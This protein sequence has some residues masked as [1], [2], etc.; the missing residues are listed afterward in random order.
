MLDLNEELERW[1]EDPKLEALLELLID[2]L[3]ETSPRNSAVE[4][5]R[6]HFKLTKNI[7]K[8]LEALMELA[9]KVA[10]SVEALEDQTEHL[11]S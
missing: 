6:N 5:L 7:S 2:Y 11:L 3:N 10:E 9:A 4:E 8:E 1:A